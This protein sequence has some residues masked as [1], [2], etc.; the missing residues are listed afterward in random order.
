MLS[1]V[2]AQTK[3]EKDVPFSPAHVEL[4]EAF[5]DLYFP[6]DAAFVAAFTEEEARSLAELE[7]LLDAATKRSETAGVHS[8]AHLQELPEWRL[9]VTQAKAVYD[10][11]QKRG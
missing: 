1:D 6:R 5:Y 7:K 11:L 3:Y 8:V 9:V 10:A 2:S 4:F